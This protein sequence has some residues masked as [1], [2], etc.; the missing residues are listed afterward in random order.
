[1]NNLYELKSSIQHLHILYSVKLSPV[2]Q[3]RALHNT[4][5]FLPT[6]SSTHPKLELFLYSLS[7]LPNVTEYPKF[8]P[9]GEMIVLYLTSTAAQIT[10]LS[11][12]YRYNQTP[13]TLFA[14]SLPFLSS[15][16]A[17]CTGKVP[18]LFH[19]RSLIVVTIMEIMSTSEE[20]HD[21]LHLCS[22]R[23]VRE[24]APMRQQHRCASRVVW[25]N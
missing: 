18:S 2:S 20:V 11:S 5:V 21:I 7:I 4:G 10:K 24:P 17:F 8:L 14:S 12:R 22:R 1:M 9:Y 6:S 25:L 15:P 16:S 23:F 19:Y 3:Q 13:I